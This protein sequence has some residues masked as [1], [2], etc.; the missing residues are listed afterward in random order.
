LND[1]HR[2]PSN[3]LY[4]VDI[5]IK[6]EPTWPGELLTASPLQS[7]SKRRL[8]GTFETP[9]EK[10]QRVSVASDAPLPDDFAA[11]IAR[12]AATV[13]EEANQVHTR[14]EK[15]RDLSPIRQ[16]ESYA[17]EENHF[18]GIVFDAHLN[19]RILSLPILESLVRY[20]L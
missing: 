10:R 13:A 20:S 9:A 2:R 17:E 16:H 7:S 18:A 11:I 14:D 8:S 5:P 1:P 6:D 19:M 15:T 3:R 12:A 4:R